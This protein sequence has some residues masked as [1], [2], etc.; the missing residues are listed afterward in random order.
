MQMQVDLI[1][2]PGRCFNSDN[3][4]LGL[5]EAEQSRSAKWTS[6]RPA[7]H[8]NHTIHPTPSACSTPPSGAPASLLPQSRSHN[9]EVK[10]HRVVGSTIPIPAMTSPHSRLALAK[11]L[12]INLDRNL[13]RTPSSALPAPALHHGVRTPSPRSSEVYSLHPTP[14]AHSGKT[15]RPRSRRE[16]FPSSSYQRCCGEV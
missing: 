16:I 3:P 10:R 9:A 8:L 5:S 14:S 2:I 4:T 13:N 1:Q 11:M 6:Q 15:V 12:G 7:K